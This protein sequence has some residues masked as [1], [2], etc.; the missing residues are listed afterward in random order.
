MSKNP[1]WKP[2]IFN[3][4][5]GDIAVYKQFRRLYEDKIKE[6]FQGLE[7]ADTMK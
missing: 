1:G 6:L 3:M 4:P 2:N 7:V 5:E